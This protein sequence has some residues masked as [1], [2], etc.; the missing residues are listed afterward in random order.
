MTYTEQ[1]ADGVQKCDADAQNEAQ[2]CASG[3]TNLTQAGSRPVPPWERRAAEAREVLRLAAERRGFKVGPNNKP[4]TSLERDLAREDSDTGTHVVYFI[5][6][7]GR[8][9]IGYTQDIRRRENTIYCQ[10]PTQTDLIRTIPGGAITEFKYHHRF[11]RSRVYGEWFRLD[12][13]LRAFLSENEK[14]AFR[15]E[16]AENIFRQWLSEQIETINASAPR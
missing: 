5:Y 14:S 8:I 4:M 9:K 13:D 12:G 7:A 6:G 10:C 15:L 11:K 3:G 2:N 1:S 16:A